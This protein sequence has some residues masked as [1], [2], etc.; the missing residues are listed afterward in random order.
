MHTSNDLPQKNHKCSKFFYEGK[1]FVIGVLIGCIFSYL[2]QGLLISKNDIG[3]SIETIKQDSDVR[4]LSYIEGRWSSSIGDIIVQVDPSQ[5]KDF[6]VIELIHNNKEESMYKIKNIEKINGLLGIVR[7]K[8]CK[9]NE[10]DENN[11]IPI[12]FN[13]IF[14]IDRTIAISYDSRITECIDVSDE[15]TRAFK[16]IE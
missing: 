12:Q 15:C 7:M 1:I 2:W 8:I 13:K 16:R 10:C 9:I 6:I 4:L 5:T 3:L 11:L 14:G